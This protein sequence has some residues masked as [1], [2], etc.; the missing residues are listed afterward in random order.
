LVL[1]GE[2]GERFKVMA[3]SRDMNLELRGMAL[4]DLQH[5]L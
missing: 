4:L 1:P 3:W 2:M 5:S